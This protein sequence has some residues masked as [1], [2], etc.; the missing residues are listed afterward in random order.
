MCDFYRRRLGGWL[1]GMEDKKVWIEPAIEEVALE[2]E[3]DVLATCY[4][5]SMSSKDS[6]NGCR[7]ARCATYP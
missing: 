4:T 6:G 1:S 2:A 7:W 5:T 3:E